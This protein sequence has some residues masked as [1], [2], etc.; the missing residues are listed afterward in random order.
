MNRTAYIAGKITGLPKGY[1]K[2]KFNFFANRLTRMGY[3][4]V[5]PAAV[6]DDTQPWDEAVGSDVKKMLQCDE[7]HLLPDW[8]ES[9]WA[10]FERDVAV[11]F[12]LQVV[13][14]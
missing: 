5:K 7:V 13:Y 2:D 12:G 10:Q 3:N 8:Q 14:H 4:V 1:V 6:T 9:R 11:R